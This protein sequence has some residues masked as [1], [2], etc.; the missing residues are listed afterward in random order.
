MT[1]RALL[2]RQFRSI[3]RLD[4]DDIKEDNRRE[5]KQFDAKFVANLLP[6]AYI[7]LDSSVRWWQS[8]RI[9]DTKPFNEDGDDCLNDFQK[10][11][12]S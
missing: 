1:Q 7:N 11:F 9:V 12:R 4:D 6:N 5:K 10:L 3:Y 2:K 8:W